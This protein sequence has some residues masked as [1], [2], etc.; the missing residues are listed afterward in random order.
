MRVP[1]GQCKW[2]I[3][4]ISNCMLGFGQFSSFVEPN[5]DHAPTIGSR[6]SCKHYRINHNFLSTIHDKRRL[7]PFLSIQ[8]PET[9]GNHPEYRYWYC[10]SWLVWTVLYFLLRMLVKMKYNNLML[11]NLRFHKKYNS[12]YFPQVLSVSPLH[13]ILMGLLSVCHQHINTSVSELSPFMWFS[14]GR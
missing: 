13:L 9:S 2:V 11:F 3:I 1:R 12:C 7:S 8:Q 4:T 14:S 10:L 5:L 6:A